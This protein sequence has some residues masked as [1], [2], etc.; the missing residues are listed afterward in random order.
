M[1]ERLIIPL[2]LIIVLSDLYIDIHYFR[3]HYHFV[4]WKRL[5][6]WMP[7][8]VMVGYTCALASIRNFV[9]SDI[10]WIDIYLFLIGLF[11][12]P[13]GVFTLCSALGWLVRKFITHTHRNWGHYIGLA[14]GIIMVC[15]F[16]Y[17]LSI[18]VRQFQVV[19]QELWFTDLPKE[20]DG[21]RI[22]LFSDAHVGSF[23]RFRHKLLKRDIDSINAQKGDLIVFAGDLQN[24]QPS[25]LNGHTDVLSSLNAPDGVVSV[26]G[27]HDYSRYTGYSAYAKMRNE[28][29]TIRRELSFGWILLRNQHIV[30]RRGNDSIVVAGEENGGK[31]KR[32]DL[33]KTLSGISPNAF[34]ILIQHDPTA[35]DKDILPHSNV[36]LTLAGHT[37]GGQIS[38]FGFRPTEL[39]Y[40]EDYGLYEK[41][42][43]YLYVSGGIGGVVP[44]RLGI[45]PE[46][47]VITLHRKQ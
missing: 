23:D 41:N 30:L 35:W 8:L 19:R 27:N 7:C 18:G 20:F 6:W 31:P 24:T 43:R 17:G 47:N 38:F 3:R 13:K 1:I 36:R 45:K 39:I 5:L 15:M 42:G 40:P 33:K 2:L 44:F 32:D 26:L 4:W 34:T 16:F 14:L 10:T 25:D 22:V 28:Q 29:Q 11:Y 21:Y 46:I 37:H 12:I 9:P